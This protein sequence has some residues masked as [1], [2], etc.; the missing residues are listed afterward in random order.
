MDSTESDIIGT[1]EFTAAAI[2]ID[3][4]ELE[5]TNIGGAEAAESFIIIDSAVPN[6][7]STPEL[8]PA[9]HI[10]SAEF[11]IINIGPSDTAMAIGGAESI[12]IPTGSAEPTTSSHLCIRSATSS[13][14]NNRIGQSDPL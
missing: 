2:Y 5:S 4:A 14:P 8:T 9:M 13:V 11:T 6:I 1:S 3:S 12:A 7:M 10:G